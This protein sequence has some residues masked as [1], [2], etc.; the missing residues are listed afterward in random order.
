[1]DVFFLKTVLTERAYV[2]T[3]SSYIQELTTLQRELTKFWLGIE[4]RSVDLNVK[5]YKQD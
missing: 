2:Y 3:E 1:M 5:I 4:K